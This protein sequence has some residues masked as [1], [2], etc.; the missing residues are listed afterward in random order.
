MIQVGKAAMFDK[1]ISLNK[2]VG[3][4]SAFGFETAICY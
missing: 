1:K 2:A 3:E 4:I